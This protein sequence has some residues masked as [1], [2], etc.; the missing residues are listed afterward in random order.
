GPAAQRTSATARTIRYLDGIVQLLRCVI[1]PNFADGPLTASGDHPKPS[2]RAIIGPPVRG[3][4]GDSPLATAVQRS[5][6]LYNRA[7]RARADNDHAG[8]RNHPP[9][10]G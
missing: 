9:G 3:S 4:R 10:G 7:E 5:G 6:R 2:R 8:F 1:S